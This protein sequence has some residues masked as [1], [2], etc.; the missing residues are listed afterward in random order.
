[1]SDYHKDITPETFD[2]FDLAEMYAR[3]EHQE[4]E[5]DFMTFQAFDD[6]G[7]LMEFTLILSSVRCEPPDPDEE[8][9][10]VYVRQRDS[11]VEQ[12]HM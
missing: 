3:A 12:D 2:Q 11:K 5:E 4:V 10:M 8:P 6:E 7:N 9:E 1:M